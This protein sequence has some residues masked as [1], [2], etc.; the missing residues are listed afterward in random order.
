MK[1]LNSKE[2][3]KK[4]I[5]KV[6]KK[7]FMRR[8]LYPKFRKMLLL[9]ERDRTLRETCIRVLK[10][11]L[12]VSKKIAPVMKQ[13]K[14]HVVIGFFIER[15][16]KSTTVAKERYQGLKFINAWQEKSPKTFPLIFGQILVSIA[17]NIEDTQLRRKAI[18]QMLTM[19]VQCPEVS[20]NVGAIR[21]VIDSLLDLS[22]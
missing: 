22:L 19:C 3:N 8:E 11:I 17:K 21:L 20:A 13:E 6:L 7:L 9:R 14:I 4:T 2:Q 18:E 10:K 16:F 15:E 12:K 1:H 5:K